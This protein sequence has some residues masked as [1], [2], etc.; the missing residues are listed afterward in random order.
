MD[1]TYTIMCR[2]ET[3]EERAEREA[4]AKFKGMLRSKRKGIFAIIQFL[5]NRATTFRKVTRDASKNLDDP[6]D[7]EGMK[8]R[9]IE[10]EVR[11]EP[12][13]PLH[14]VRIL[15]TITF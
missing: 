9:A 11:G 1:A 13:L 5:H 8:R 4:R 15:L 12:R 14:F 7:E 10:T 6:K 3:P 2:Y